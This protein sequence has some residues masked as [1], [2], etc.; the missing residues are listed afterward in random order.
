[1]VSLVEQAKR[2]A[3]LLDSWGEFRCVNT[4]V[5]MPVHSKKLTE[6]DIYWRTLGM[7]ARFKDTIS[8]MPSF[9]DRDLPA[10]TER[11]LDESRVFVR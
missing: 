3:A 5:W 4:G 1:M 10:F 7:T 8:R 6:T 9:A 11:L 2:G